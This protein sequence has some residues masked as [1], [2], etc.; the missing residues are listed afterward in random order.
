RGADP[1]PLVEVARFFRRDPGVMSRGVWLLEER[2]T[3]E[4]ELQK[5]VDRLQVVICEGR[6][7]R[8]ARRQA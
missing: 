8:M 2:L 3:Q 1:I 4:K 6:K 5:R 7:P